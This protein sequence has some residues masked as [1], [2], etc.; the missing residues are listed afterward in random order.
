MNTLKLHSFHRRHF[1]LIFIIASSTS[2]DSYRRFVTF[3]FYW[4]GICMKRAKTVDNF[5]HQ[6]INLVDS[7]WI[8]PHSKSIYSPFISRCCW[9]S[10]SWRSTRFVAVHIS[11][12]ASLCFPWNSIIL[13]LLQTGPPG[14]PGVAGPAG[15]PG[16][17]GVAGPPGSDGPAGPKV[18]RSKTLKLFFL[19]LN[20]VEVTAKVQKTANS[21]AHN[22][23]YAQCIPIKS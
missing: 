10:R 15:P 9:N 3:E 14:E 7:L 21:N 23:E 17:P 16:E 19:F 22:A 13:F 11:S 12:S 5:A 18:R 20:R 4:N 1:F 6:S 2:F 8:F